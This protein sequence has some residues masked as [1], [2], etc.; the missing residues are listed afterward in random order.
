MR[1]PAFIAW[2]SKPGW[3][4]GEERERFASHA[5]DLG[6]DVSPLGLGVL[7]ASDRMALGQRTALVGNLRR[8]QDREALSAEALASLLDSEDLASRLIDD[9]WGDYVAIGAFAA[10]RPRAALRA[11]FGDLAC[12]W[13]EADEHLALASSVALLSR[14]DMPPPSVDWQSLGRFLAATDLRTGGTCLA[15]IGELNGG[16]MA[17]VSQRGTAFERHWSPWDWTTLAQQF[18]TREDAADAIGMAIDASVSTR[19]QPHD[20][21]VLLLSGGLDSS[22]VAA[23]LAGGERAFTALTMVVGDRQGDEREHARAVA[24]RLHVPLVERVREADMVDLSRPL[25]AQ[26]PRPVGSQFRQA[27]FRAADAV[28]RDLG[29]TAILDGGGGDNMF[30]SLRSVAPLVDAFFQEGPTAAV[31]R[32]AASIARMTNVGVVEVAWQALARTLTRRRRYRWAIDPS[33]LDPQAHEGFVP[34]HP[35][36]EPPPG[37][38]PGKAAQVAL[39]LAA[40]A[41]TESPDG[42]RDP[43]ILSPL[44][45]QCVAEAALRVPSWM[46]FEDG[47][48]R[49]IVRR[50]YADRLP[51]SIV[52]RRSKGT[53]TGFLSLLV[54]ANAAMLRPFLLDGLLAANRVLD[55]PGV[56]ALLAGGPARDLGF[57]RLLQLADAEAWARSWA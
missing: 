31:C 49:A 10:G 33:L 27:T 40:T 18:A 15:E 46:W 35:W 11:P 51:G 26:L 28:A 9:H 44:V 21:S 4:N 16:Q 37:T 13:Q 3:F 57:A 5:A 30:C 54:E 56:E 45:S 36:L 38:P 55:R 50:A 41:V 47:H 48:N 43:P 23:A 7:I 12:Y 6:M 24:E 42:E 39:I 32:T 14:F 19:V 2:L 29:A 17:S 53:P 1:K 20:R 8:R 22:V 34:R 25:A 52:R